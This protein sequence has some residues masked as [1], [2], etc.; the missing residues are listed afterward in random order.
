MQV[1]KKYHVF[2][3]HSLYVNKIQPTAVSQPPKLVPLDGTF[4]AV[5]DCPCDSALLR[6]SNVKLPSAARSYIIFIENAFLHVQFIL[7]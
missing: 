1:F 5:F 2:Y 4:E 6:L 7:R 3:L